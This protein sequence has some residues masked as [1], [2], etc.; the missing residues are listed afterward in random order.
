MP[1]ELS[2]E[3]PYPMLPQNNYTAVFYELEKTIQ[4]SIIKIATTMSKFIRTTIELSY[5]NSY[6]ILPQHNYTPV[7]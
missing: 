7:F 2:Q 5:V 4:L 1:I 3:N 6:A